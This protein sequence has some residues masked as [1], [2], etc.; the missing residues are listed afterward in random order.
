MQTTLIKRSLLF[1]IV[2]TSFAI[3]LEAQPKSKRSSKRTS[4]NSNA[5]NT[6]ADAVVASANGWSYVKGEWVHPDGYKYVNGRVLRTTAVAGKAFPKPP[7]KLALENAQKSPVK[8]APAPDNAKSAAE[9]AADA[10]RRNLTPSA[11]PQTGS[12]L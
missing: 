6:T 3:A 1:V 9:K 4:T 10:R 2:L 11:A 7:G 8:T 5:Q 12:H